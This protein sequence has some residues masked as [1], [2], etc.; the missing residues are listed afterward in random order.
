MTWAEEQVTLPQR[1]CGGF[2]RQQRFCSA[3]CHVANSREEARFDAAGLSDIKHE[4]GAHA[5][6]HRAG[7]AA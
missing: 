2:G 7:I 1:K 5:E 6:Y 3:A 4:I